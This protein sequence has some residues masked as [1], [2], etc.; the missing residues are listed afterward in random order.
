MSGR[1]QW[2]RRLVVLAVE[3][4]LALPTAAKAQSQD[5]TQTPGHA[6]PQDQART[7]GTRPPTERTVQL[8]AQVQQEL[9]FSNTQDFEDARRGFIGTEPDLTITDKDGNVVWSLKPY[10]FIQGRE[11]PP[12]VNPSLWR[13]AQLNMQNGLFKVTDGIYQVRGYDLSVMTIIEGKTGT[14]VVDPL[15]TAETGRAAYHYCVRDLKDG[16]GGPP[17]YVSG[18]GSWSGGRR[19]TEAARWQSPEPWP[20]VR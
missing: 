9:P 18:A 7:P 4:A 11:A 13:Q 10:Q 17:G 6:Q 2:P 5:Q 14:L 19:G 1:H 20:A 12:T 16:Q 8:N 15:I 3:L